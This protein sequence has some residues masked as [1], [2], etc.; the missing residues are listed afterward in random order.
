MQLMSI[1]GDTGVESCSICHIS[2]Q[3]KYPSIRQRS[4]MNHIERVHLKVK[5]YECHFCTKRFHS[6]A[7]RA[8][9]VTVKHREEHHKIKGIITP[10]RTR[11]PPV[12]EEMLTVSV[13]INTDEDSSLKAEKKYIDV[14]SDT[15]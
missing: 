11:L 15:D 13:S 7:Q 14:A 3:G 10:S 12:T 8:S 1:D 9:H 5:A 4:L 6:K 2:Y